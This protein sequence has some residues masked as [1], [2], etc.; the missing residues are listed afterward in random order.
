MSTA[1]RDSEFLQVRYQGRAGS[2]GTYLFVDKS[3][4]SLRADIESPA[5]GV[6][7]GRRYDSISVGDFLPG[8][9]Q[10]R[11]IRML[12]LRESPVV[13]RLVNADHEIGDIELTDLLAALTERSAFGRS[14]AGEGFGEPGKDNPPAL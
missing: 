6:L 13:F 11:E 8:I 4:L 5:R 7:P 10:D 9:A 2:R 1:L 12:L 14:A 3:N